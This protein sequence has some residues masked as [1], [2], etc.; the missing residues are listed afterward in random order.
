MFLALYQ[1]KVAYIQ[2][3]SNLSY[4]YYIAHYVAL[5]STRTKTAIFGNRSA[6]AALDGCNAVASN[7]CVQTNHHEI[8]TASGHCIRNRAPSPK[9]ALGRHRAQPCTLRIKYKSGPFPPQPRKA[10]VRPTDPTMAARTPGDLCEFRDALRLC[11]LQAPTSTDAEQDPGAR[12]CSE[13]FELRDDEYMRF[14][15]HAPKLRSELRQFDEFFVSTPSARWMIGTVRL[16]TPCSEDSQEYTF[17]QIHGGVKPLLR[18]AVIASRA[19]ASDSVWAIVRTGL[20]PS[21][22]EKT[23]M[24][25]RP[26]D[27]HL[28]YEICV[29]A[30]VLRIFVNGKL[31]VDK[32]I[33]YWEQYSN[34]FKAGCTCHCRPVC[35]AAR[36]SQAPFVHPITNR[37]GPAL[38]PSLLPSSRLCAV[39]RHRGG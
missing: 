34:Y 25:P 39:W 8:P 28:E 1:P 10:A 36:P 6:Q 37:D 9:T 5:L 19:G 18:L 38:L 26:T 24:V 7:T 35:T 11:K 13:Y 27:G 29:K 21:D 20:G 15:A 31:Y 4:R 14:V 12:F 33:S 22:V 30:S 23:L 17:A 3:I 32:D 2:Y 16:P